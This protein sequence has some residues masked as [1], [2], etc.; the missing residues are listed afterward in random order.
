MEVKRLLSF[1]YHINYVI[2]NLL[3]F[4]IYLFN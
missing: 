3:E 4:K 1:T 2:D